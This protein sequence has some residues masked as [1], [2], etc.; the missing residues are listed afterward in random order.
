MVKRHSIPPFML[1]TF[2]EFAWLIAFALLLMVHG[3]DEDV[4]EA[5]KG[6]EAAQ[7]KL[8]ARAKI[9]EKLGKERDDDRERIRDLEAKLAKGRET[10]ESFS[11]ALLGKIGGEGDLKVSVSNLLVTLAMEEKTNRSLGQVL[12]EQQ[13]ANSVL[14][15]RLGAEQAAH[16]ALSNSYA[17]ALVELAALPSNVRD[18]PKQIAELTAALQK[19]EQQSK[20]AEVRTQVAEQKLGSVISEKES[21]DKRLQS[22]ESAEFGVRREIT[23]LPNGQLGRVVIMLD[24]SSSMR[25][26]AAWNE[27]KRLVR[28]WLTYL[29]IRECALITFNSRVRI[30]PADADRAFLRLRDAEGKPDERNRNLLL[31]A[32]EKA[33]GET[34]TD[35]LAAFN[36]AYGLGNSDLVLLFTDGRPRT[37]T[38]STESLVPK[39][40]ELVTR[41]SRI[42]ILAVALG[43][44]ESL[45]S[46]D[47]HAGANLQLRFLKQ[48][49]KLSGGVFMAR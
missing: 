14:S 1:F 39:I 5:R 24:T 8:A 12:A 26:S 37:A 7:G 35:T 38:A 16:A 19:Y 30:F 17:R 20:V 47:K 18:L 43:D 48:L 21:L 44:Y 49:A 22:F 3:K 29:P 15:R 4:S 13:S 36:A 42:P 11:S 6:L 25:T 2:A 40:Y 28:V 34:Y 10:L 23:G 46:S 27:A 31:D 41:N 32:V 9:V 33:P 45:E